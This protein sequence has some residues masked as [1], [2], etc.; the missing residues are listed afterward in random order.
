ML[1]RDIYHSENK[2]QGIEEGSENLEILGE[3]KSKGE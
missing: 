3:G 1:G 2:T